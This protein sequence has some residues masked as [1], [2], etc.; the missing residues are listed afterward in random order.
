MNNNIIKTLKNEMKEELTT[1]ALQRETRASVY[2]AFMS[3]LSVCESYNEM[4]KV[5]HDFKKVA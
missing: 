4:C 1:I 5:L 3:R 2:N